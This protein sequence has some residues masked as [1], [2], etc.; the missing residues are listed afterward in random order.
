MTS[1]LLH[2]RMAEYGPTTLPPY[3]HECLARK[4]QLFKRLEKPPRA[5][6]GIMADLPKQEALD[7]FQK[8]LNRKAFLEC[9]LITG[10]HPGSRGMQEVYRKV[11]SN[12]LIGFLSF[13]DIA[14]YHTPTHVKIEAIEKVYVDRARREI[15]H[16][17]WEFFINA[18]A[19][20]RLH[21]IQFFQACRERDVLKQIPDRVYQ[22]A[23]VFARFPSDKSMA[24]KKEKE[25]LFS[26]QASRKCYVRAFVA[27]LDTC[28]ARPEAAY[29]KLVKKT[30]PIEVTLSKIIDLLA[31]G[32]TYMAHQQMQRVEDTSDEAVLCLDETIK[33]NAPRWKCPSRK[34]DNL[35]PDHKRFVVESALILLVNKR[36]LH[37]AALFEDD[38]TD[39]AYALSAQLLSDSQK[40]P[41]LKSLEA[42]VYTNISRESLSLSFDPSPRAKALAA[43]AALPTPAPA[44]PHHYYLDEGTAESD[45][46][47]S[48]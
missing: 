13:W 27:A 43:A 5:T 4:Q 3:P 46:E 33:Q 9:G 38:K 2:S 48:W 41:L 15:R 14:P 1:K 17:A 12:S 19:K 29:K 23:W 24:K 34:W 26:L 35:A 45:D 37:I 28:T 18:T 42:L 40:V 22:A 31:K 6:R 30:Q 25:P 8:S 11:H 39:I 44:K 10:V 47:S 36:L 20:A 21:C 32:C 7:S 16:I